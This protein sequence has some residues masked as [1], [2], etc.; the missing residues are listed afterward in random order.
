MRDAVIVEAVRTPVGKRNGALSG[1]HPV[2]LSAH[3]LRA[4]AERGGIDPGEV[5][6]VIWGCVSQVGEQTLDIARNAPLAAGWPESVTGVTVDRQ[7]GSSQ[8]AVHF[9]AAGLIAGHY[10]VVVAGGVESMSRVPMFSALLDQDPLGSEF[11][12]RYGGVAPNQGT[13]AEMIAERWGF[14]RTQLDEFSLGSHEKAAA[15]Q[16]DGRFDAQIAPVT[17]DDGTVV[18]QDEGVRRGGTVAKLASLK[19][20]FKPDGG[21]ITAGNSSQIS[22]GSAALLLTTSEKA[23]EL[24]LAP[25]ARVHT[26]V[27]AGADPVIML[28]API[29]A[30]QKVLRKSGLRLDEIG[31]FE[32][33]EAFASVPLAW[34]AE[35]GADAKALNPNGGAIA[36]GHPLGGSGARIATTLVHHMRDN[37]IRYGLQTMCEGGGQ[38]N[39]TI[40]ELL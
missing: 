33:N 36:L 28:T 3:V 27:L 6:D 23:R 22:D 38:A 21:V 16:D 2:N 12:A 15:A 40:F 5:D 19:T 24:G 13:G 10:D 17:L 26:A 31:A 1:V 32:V 29:P 14:S 35:I 20:V 34:L 30:T 25:I 39:A 18:S 11:L 9:A 4:L 37:G 7:C 8:Q